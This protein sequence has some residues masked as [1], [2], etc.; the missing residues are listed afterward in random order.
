MKS[1]LIEKVW[2]GI[3]TTFLPSTVDNVLCFLSM[4]WCRR[5]QCKIGSWFRDFAP[6]FGPDDHFDLCQLLTFAA[7]KLT[8]SIY[9]WY[10]YLYTFTILAIHVGMKIYHTWTVMGKEFPSLDYPWSLPPHGNFSL[11]KSPGWV[12][13]TFSP[14]FSGWTPQTN[15]PG[16]WVSLRWRF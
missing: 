7:W 3:S 2:F 10:V 11:Q 13:R 16:G 14:L 6:L 4:I 9:V 12:W 5:K 1:D 15:L 8:H